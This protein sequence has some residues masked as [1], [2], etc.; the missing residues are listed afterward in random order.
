MASS[1]RRAR[2]VPHTFA[3]QQAL[4]LGIPAPP[5]LIPVPEAQRWLGMSPEVFA[6]LLLSGRLPVVPIG[7]KTRIEDTT[8]LAQPASQDPLHRCAWKPTLFCSMTPLPRLCS[9]FPA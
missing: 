2:P 9:P 6:T 4:P 3:W 1:S 8:L 5:Q 7:R